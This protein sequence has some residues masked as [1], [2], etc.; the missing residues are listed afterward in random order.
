M[1]NALLTSALDVG[2]RS[3]SPPVRFTYGEGYP[4]IHWVG[5]WVGSTAGLDAVERRKI[6]CP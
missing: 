2:E 5:S 3:A 6:P 4:D 1:L